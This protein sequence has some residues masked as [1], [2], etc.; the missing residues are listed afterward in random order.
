MMMLQGLDFAVSNYFGFLLPLANFDYHIKIF[1]KTNHPQKIK[2]FSKMP[3]RYYEVARSYVTKL[4]SVANIC[5]LLK[6]SAD[7]MLNHLQKCLHLFSYNH[8][9][10]Y[11]SSLDAGC[12]SVSCAFLNSS[13]RQKKTQKLNLPGFSIWVV[14]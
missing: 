9:S 14:S 11:L 3:R 13:S 7:Q 10:N 4:Y 12:R 8:T 1:T 6:I 5:S 2:S